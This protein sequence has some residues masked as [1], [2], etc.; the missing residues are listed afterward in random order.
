MDIT[1]TIKP[2]NTLPPEKFILIS[3]KAAELGI[4]E[5]QFVIN[6]ILAGLEADDAPKKPRN[7][8]EAA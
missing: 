8:K 7:R 1:L 6:A 4:T 2:S 3:E 5:D